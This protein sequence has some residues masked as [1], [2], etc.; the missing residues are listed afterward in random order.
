MN[1]TNSL[2][3]QLAIPAIPTRA[4][5]A[6][7]GI[8]TNSP[9]SV[10]PDHRRR[11]THFAARRTNSSSGS[12]HPG[13]RK[14]LG[15]TLHAKA[16]RARRGVVPSST[17]PSCP[18]SGVSRARRAHATRRLLPW[19]R[20][21]SLQRTAQQAASPQAWTSRPPLAAAAQRRTQP[22]PLRT[23]TATATR[24]RGLTGKETCC[25]AAVRGSARLVGQRSPTRQSLCPV[26][27]S[28]PDA[29]RRARLLSLPA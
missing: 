26:H 18:S 20:Q 24:R 9:A 17:R 2:S 15:S 21:S 23:A 4:F 28:A 6:A 11:R 12:T 8:A 22:P 19:P 10:I 13:H 7:G 29:C 5:P 16:A 27:P 25:S 1:N 14:G 3:R